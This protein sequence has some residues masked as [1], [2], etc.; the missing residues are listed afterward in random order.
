[1]GKG[2]S[3]CRHCGEMHG[4]IVMCDEKHKFFEEKR[5]REER[6]AEEHRRAEARKPRIQ[7]IERK[8]HNPSWGDRLKNY[9]QTG[10]NTFYRKEE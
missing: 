6:Q 10:Y 3:R 2:M 1:M 5:I 8:D 7:I 4:N 9:E